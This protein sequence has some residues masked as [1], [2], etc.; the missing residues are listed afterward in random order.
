MIIG[1]D[2][3]GVI[4]D[5]E[6]EYIVEA[7]LYN[8]KLGKNKKTNKE[9]FVDDNRYSW[10]KEE[11]ERFEKNWIKVVKKANFMPGALSIIK[12]LLKEKHKIILVTARLEDKSKEI[13]ESYLKKNGLKFYK[14][15]WNTK[16]KISICKKEKIDIMVDDYWKNVENLSKNKI[17]TLYF[18]D[19]NMKK[20]EENKYLK[21]VFN[22]ISNFGELNNWGEIYKYIYIQ[23]KKLK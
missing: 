3:D 11:R 10:T 20:L 23:D 19:T 9:D 18:R 6:Q 14:Y 12:L 8:I 21:E 13:T 16:D 17:K 1:L 15:Y 2:I 4:L 5:T 22:T 7:E